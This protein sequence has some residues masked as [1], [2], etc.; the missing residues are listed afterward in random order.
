MDV[1]GTVDAFSIDFRHA[2]IGIA[3]RDYDPDQRIPL[4]G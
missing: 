1:L 4:T 2:E 3:P